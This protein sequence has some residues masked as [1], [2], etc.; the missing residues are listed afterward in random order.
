VNY[1]KDIIVVKEQHNFELLRANRYERLYNELN[2]R[3][4]F[5]ES[6]YKAMKARLSEL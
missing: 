4:E 3:I 6:E 5:A 1:D 2:E